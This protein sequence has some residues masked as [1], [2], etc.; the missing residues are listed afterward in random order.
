[1]GRRPSGGE[2]IASGRRA[3]WG[4]PPW[5]SRFQPRA[6]ALPSEA[7][8]AIIG[9]G[10]TGLAVA[11][12]VRR[13]APAWRVVLLEENRLGN[14][15][16]GRSGGIA[17]EDTAAGPLPGLERVLED[18]ATRLGA[19]GIECDFE[20]TAAWEIGRRDGRA[21]SPLA[22]QDS[23]RLRV[24]NE[25]PGGLLDPARLVSGLANAAEQSGA[26]LCENSCVRSIRFEKPLRLELESA[27]LR[28]ERLVL[29][30]DGSGLGLGLW[31]A[32][33]QPKF[34][35][36]V[37]TAPLADEQLRELTQEP[38]KPF[39]TL[40]LP[41]LWGRPLPGRRLMFGGGLVHL[42]NAPELAELDVGRGEAAR[43][44]ALLEQRVRG[45]VP[46]L[47]GVE[48]THRWGGPMLF[49]AA[50]RPIF[51]PHPQSQRALVLGGYTGQ[52]VAL[53]VCLAHWAAEALVSGRALPAWGRPAL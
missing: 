45:L 6:L 2:V 34:T 25:V 20:L 5:E 7:E 35:L 3:G 44:L 49:A 46:A 26:L 41:Y 47:R 4:A 27:A 22:W 14:G 12:W 28:A 30:V 43:L 24:V 38:L 11:C 32:S 48:F 9:G 37:A 40:D 36:A 15:A 1:M 21:D 13:L 29:A 10:F 18:F 42:Q 23:G 16:S 39:Y 8:L 51:C 52:G 33:A 50:G 17:L 19:L 53:S 31:P